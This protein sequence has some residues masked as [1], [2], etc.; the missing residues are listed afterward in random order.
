MV[1]IVSGNS[2]G[3]NLTSLRTLGQQGLTGM[4]TEGRNGQ[5][6]Y[7]NVSN[8]NLVLQSQDDYLEA[9]GLD[10]A[11]IRTYNSQG[12]LNDDNGDNWSSG[13]FV[14]PLQ[15]SGTLN[16]AGSSIRRT[17][18]DGAA[19][20]YNYDSG[21]GLYVSSDGDG[22]YDTIVRIPAGSQLEWRDGSTGRVERYEGS[23]AYRLL[24]SRD[25]SGNALTF[26]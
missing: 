6:A 4:A 9:R 18:R 1:A 15:L 3:L 16:S 5:E 7:V 12:L 19:A 21:R 23:G 22:A 20:I 14:Q 24:S 13:A 26:A 11:T 8:G 2:L 17:D 10:A 25:P